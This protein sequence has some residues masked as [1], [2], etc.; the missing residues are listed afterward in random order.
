MRLK[1]KADHLFSLIFKTTTRSNK[2]SQANLAF[3]TIDTR[4]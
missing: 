2:K 1:F 4:I 3:Y